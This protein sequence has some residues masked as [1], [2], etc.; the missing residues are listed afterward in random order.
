MLVICVKEEAQ[1]TEEGVC[2]AGVTPVPAAQLGLAPSLLRPMPL[3]SL[4]QLLAKA[5]GRCCT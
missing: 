4:P 2:V 5:W 1:V 3:A